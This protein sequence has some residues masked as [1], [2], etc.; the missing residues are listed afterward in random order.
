MWLVGKRPFEGNMMQLAMQYLSTPPPSLREQIPSI[1]PGLEA[2]VL[3]ALSKAPA[4]RFANVQDFTAE[5]E[6]GWQP[7]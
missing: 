3:R 4:E 5:F 6:R 1:T 7:N 2:V